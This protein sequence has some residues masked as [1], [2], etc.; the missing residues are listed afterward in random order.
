MNLNNI[1]LPNAFAK[2][3]V[4]LN[5]NKFYNKYISVLK[6]ISIFLIIFILLLENNKLDIDLIKVGYYCNSIKYGGVERVMALLINYLS[7]EKMFIHFLLTKK[8]KLEGEYSIPGTIQRIYL[9]EKKISLLQ[10]IKINNIDILIYNFYEKSEIKEL[11]KLKTTK[12]IYYDHSSYFYWI[13]LNNYKFQDTVYY[14]YKNCNYVI[15]LIPLENDYLFKKWGIKSI[16]MDNPTTF[17]YD[18]VIP[19]DLTEKNIIMIGRVNDPIKRFD[20]GLRIMERIIEEV[21]DCKM[22]IVSKSSKKYEKLIHKLK[23][24]KYVK[25][26]GFKNDIKIYLKNSSLHLFPSLSESYPM[27]LSET[28][29]FGIPSIICGLDYLALAKGGTII[30]YDD[31]PVTIAKEAIKLMKD[32]SLR[33]K[34][35]NEARKSMKKRKNENIAKKWVKLFL[36]IYKGNELIF[37]KISDDHDKITEKEANTI[38]NNQLILLRKRKPILKNLTLEQ[39]KNFSFS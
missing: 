10:A 12:I 15:S 24:E 32:D 6:K 14:E 28:K 19:S 9:S 7:K 17:E 2:N 1:K 16:L 37:K 5:V 35:G 13:Y 36:S 4:I 39:L 11:N 27:V 30:I 34:L 23:L 31:N 22:N 26:V 29:I 3:N 33:K 20:L 8:G 18:S 21:P 38:L 25:F